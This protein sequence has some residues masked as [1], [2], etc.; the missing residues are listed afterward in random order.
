M[1]AFV[2][3]LLALA[4]A[5][6]GGEPPAEGKWV[7]IDKSAQRLRAYENGKLF[8]QTRVSTGIKGGPPRGTY[9]AGD[10]DRMHF[11]KLFKNAP[12]P[13]AV[14]LDNNYF[15]H[16]FSSVPSRPAS[17]G[18]VRVPLTGD[19]PAKRFFEW[20]ERG[21]PIEVVGYAGR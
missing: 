9:Y 14:Q 20:V 6:F 4:A 17:H 8:L 2:I 15:I 1:K 3:A 5:A 16:G 19:N 18:C 12:M 11:S 7:E 13:Y 10:K 21:T